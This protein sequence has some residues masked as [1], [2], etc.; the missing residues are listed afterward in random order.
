M[1]YKHPRYWTLS[2]NSKWSR[3]KT[4]INTKTRYHN[5]VVLKY[6]KAH[7]NILPKDLIDALGL[8]FSK[9]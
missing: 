9:F 6:A 4:I 1:Y 3:L 2:L 8:V 7:T 5:E